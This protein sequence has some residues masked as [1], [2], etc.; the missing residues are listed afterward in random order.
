MG[1][2]VMA[3]VISAPLQLAAAAGVEVSGGYDSTVANFTL[4]PP[5]WGDGGILRTAVDVQVGHRTESVQQTLRAR[6]E[7]FYAG[8]DGRSLDDANLTALTRYNLRWSPDDEWRV[9]V[10]GG[11]NIGLA[12]MLVQGGAA[13]RG[14]PFQYGTFGEYAASAQLVRAFRDRYRLQP[15]FG[16]NG[17]HTVEVP[18]GTPRGDM[19]VLRAGLVGSADVGDRDTLGVALNTE[20][21]GM[22]GLG[23][24]IQRVTPFATWRHAWS[25]TF[26]S[27]VSAGADFIQDQT[28]PLRNRWNVGPYVNLVL[29]RVVPDARLAFTLAGRYEFTSVN[30]VACGGAL[31][32]DGLCPPDQAIAGG[33]G[34]VGGGTL[35]FAWRP[36]EDGQ[37]TVVGIATADY[38]VTQNFVRAGDRVLPQT[39]DV[40]NMNVTASVNLRWVFTRQ[41]SA[42]ARYT[43]LFQ[44]VEEPVTM[45]DI[46]RHLLLA[47]V[48]F[49]LTAGEADYLDGV[50][51]FQE[52]EIMHAIRAAAAAAPS[53]EAVAAEQS[54]AGQDEGVLADPLDPAARPVAPPPL[55]P[56]EPEPRPEPYP[57]GD[58]RRVPPATGPA[59][60][61][62][63]AP[64]AAP[65]GPTPS[66]TTPP[67]D[68]TEGPTG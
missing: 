68:R 34:R 49:S 11:Y 16:V 50:V 9:E 18:P 66:P 6:G 12:S 7:M 22:A 17:R 31:R 3:L 29:T 4:T 5:Q 41:I 60:P 23:D 54:A 39:R 43:F 51:P 65:A 2:T 59:T 45:Q 63:S 13:T 20:R 27:G 62:T 46:R 35:Q 56:G 44:H 21:L 64:A 40:G 37:L 55:R 14:T 47:G 38:G 61:P 57:V 10:N 19:I 15:F 48:T 52:A 24:W 1:P 32:P 42:F 30:S 36:L 8:G 25:D 58:P 26:G 33:V 53:A 67:R 28:D